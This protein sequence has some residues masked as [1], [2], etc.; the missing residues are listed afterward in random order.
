MEVKKNW[1]PPRYGEIQGTH[2]REIVML[3]GQGCFHNK[4][5]FCDYF[6]DRSR[7]ILENYKVNRAALAKVHGRYGEL[8][9]ICSGSFQELDFL[10]MVEIRNSCKTYGIERISLECHYHYKDTLEVYREF[11]APMEVAFRVGV[12]SFDVAWRENL[13]N[14]GMGAVEPK[15]IAK[16]FDYCNLLVGEEHQ[17]KEQI[18]RDIELGLRYF[19]RVCLG[20]LEE[21]GTKV[22]RNQQLVDWFLDYASES[23]QDNPAIYLL[24]DTGDFPVGDA[25][26]TEK[27][28]S[29]WDL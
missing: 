28:L 25:C 23:L 15:E 1:N 19:K 7:D 3:R 5:A 4:C 9:V 6:L 18:L 16:Y 11:F 24:T 21:N 27:D 8:E 26:M 29:G 22:K 10:S 14:K 12:E 17:T 20:V 2:P 13:M